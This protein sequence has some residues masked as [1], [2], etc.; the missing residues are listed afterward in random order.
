[1][2]RW[3]VVETGVMEMESCRL[4]LV[5]GM[6]DGLMPVEDSLLMMEFGGVKEGRFFTGRAHM[7]YPEANGVVYPW[8]EGVMG[9]GK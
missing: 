6:E 3:S 2:G 9:T 7:G 1:M 8:M 4:L 5:N